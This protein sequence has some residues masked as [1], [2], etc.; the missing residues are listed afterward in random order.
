VEIRAIPPDDRQAMADALSGAALVTLLSDYETHP[1][2]VLEALAFRRSVLVADTSGLRELATNGLVRSI[3]VHSTP[4]QVATA[5]L[6]QLDR[7]H[8]PQNVF[9]PTWDTCTESLLALYDTV[10]RDHAMRMGIS[11]CAA[12]L[13]S[14]DRGAALGV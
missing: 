2:A 8:V 12:A 11:E 10:W 5:V 1:I 14:G 13:R 9:L 6:D 7:P 4:R 3:P